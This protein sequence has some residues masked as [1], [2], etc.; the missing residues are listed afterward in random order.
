MRL[1]SNENKFE[2]KGQSLL[3]GHSGVVSPRMDAFTSANSNEVMAKGQDM[4]NIFTPCCDFLRK[5]IQSMMFFFKM[6]NEV[7]QQTYFC[8][9]SLL[10]ILEGKVIKS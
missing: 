5:D 9:K 3:S 6:C 8:I 7:R 10:I 4:I 1:Q 2:K